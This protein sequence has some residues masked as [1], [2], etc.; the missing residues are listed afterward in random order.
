MSGTSRGFMGLRNFHIPTA[1]SAAIDK[2]N[3]KLAGIVDQ[4]HSINAQLR[5]AGV[6]EFKA[7]ETLKEIEWK[8][9]HL[10]KGY[11]SAMVLATV[12]P[13]EVEPAE[14]AIDYR[15]AKDALDQRRTET[16]AKISELQMKSTERR[17]EGERIAVAGNLA[18]R[19]ISAI[20]RTDW[21]QRPAALTI[22]TRAQPA[23]GYAPGDLR[24]RVMEIQANL[25]CTAAELY[26][27]EQ[28]TEQPLKE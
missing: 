9:K 6:E 22:S 11:G 16:M 24:R 7:Q 21:P 8:R 10:A 28:E 25:E 15:N 12:F 18:E 19:Q 20:K 14:V 3:A 26:L 1:K 5:E 17:Q 4:K 23:P 2:V 27:L 13:G